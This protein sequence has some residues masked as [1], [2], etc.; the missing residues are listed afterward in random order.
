MNTLYQ[1]KLSRRRTLQWIAA[2]SVAMT[3]AYRANGVTGTLVAFHPEAKGYGTDPKL[4]EPE[5]TWPRIMQ[6]YQLQQAAILSDLILPGSESAPPP[7][8]IGVP[9]FV[10]EWVS[11]PYPEQQADRPIILEGLKRID[12]QCI[13]R[14]RKPFH[15]MDGTFRAQLLEDLAQQSAD[16]HDTPPGVFFRRFRSLVVS[17]YYTTPEGFKDIGYTG[18][19]AMQS[20]PAITAEERAILDRALSKL[21]LPASSS[22]RHS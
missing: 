18:N 4:L 2:S 22:D 11:A 16:A 20:Y 9:E 14:W 19:V 21:G 1:P 6:P 3:L 5:V 17:A 7:S 12:V 15:E 10:D 13:Q 8:S